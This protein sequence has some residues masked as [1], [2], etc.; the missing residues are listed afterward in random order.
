[1]NIMQRTISRLASF[2]SCDGNLWG[3]GVRYSYYN[4]NAG[5][6]KG[7]EEFQQNDL[8]VNGNN[9]SNMV[10][11]LNILD[12]GYRAKLA[13]W[14]QGKQLAL[15]PPSSK[16]DQRFKCR[17]TVYAATIAHDRSGNEQA[18]NRIQGKYML[19]NKRSSDRER[20]YEFLRRIPI[21]RTYNSPRYR[22]T[23]FKFEKHERK[24]LTTT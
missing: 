7:Q 15:Q 9:E 20:L 2:A 17:K 8:V 5:Y 16:S 6:L 1:M 3:G 21:R 24:Q 11:F 10:E 23:H 18:V 22:G 12:R 4:K 19:K 14:S 13:A